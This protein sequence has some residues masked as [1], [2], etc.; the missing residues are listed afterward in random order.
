[1]HH[2]TSVSVFSKQA[3]AERSRLSESKSRSRRGRRARLLA[4]LIAL[5]CVGA[6]NVLAATRTVTNLNDSGAGSLRA[7]IAA[8]AGGAVNISG[9]TIA[10]G[11]TAG[12]GGGIL[13]T[14]SASVVTVNNCSFANNNGHDGGGIVNKGTLSITNSTFLGNGYDS[15]GG[16][17]NQGTATVVNC[18]FSGNH[19]SI[20][21]A[22]YNLSG[23]LTLLNCTL[24]ANA[25][26]GSPGGLA[27]S[28]TANIQN[29]IIYMRYTTVTR[30][31]QTRQLFASHLLV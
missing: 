22:I 17:N 12:L 1:M 3:Q 2:T 10:D 16:L 9:L 5:A 21:A 15:G 11:S 18:T 14:N 30:D 13:I 7:A 25:S 27:Q 23:T 6:P 20:G 29:T 24:T 26:G 4:V 8:S 28:A 19:S 31:A